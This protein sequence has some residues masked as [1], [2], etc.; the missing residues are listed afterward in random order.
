MTKIT[1][2][3]GDFLVDSIQSIVNSIMREAGADYW[4]FGAVSALTSK[5]SAAAT[6][7]FSPED[8]AAGTYTNATELTV[9]ETGGRFEIAGLTTTNLPNGR[10]SWG[11]FGQFAEDVFLGRIPE[12]IDAYS[13]ILDQVNSKLYYYDA[14][15]DQTTDGVST[16]PTSIGI[17]GENE[18]A[19]E[20]FMEG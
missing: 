18:L 11:S 16:N 8:G 2:I 12:L 4:A 3:S 10:T 20:D 9:T 15:A 1:S 17:E 19:S 5:I 13:L 6:F 14:T 7:F